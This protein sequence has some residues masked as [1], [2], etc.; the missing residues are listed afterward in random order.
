MTYVINSTAGAYYRGWDSPVKPAD[1]AYRAIHYGVVVLDISDSTIQGQF[2]CSVNCVQT[3]SD[4]MPREESVCNTPGEVIDAFSIAKSDGPTAIREITNH[5]PMEPA[6][7]NYPNPFNPSTTISYSI[8]NVA[9]VRIDVYDLPGR[10]VA[11]LVDG[12]KREGVYTC[13]WFG[14]DD[15]GN[16]LASGFYIAW[17]RSGNFVRSTKMLLVH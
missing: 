15:H 5:V 7:K 8:P 13:V 10:K 16:D 2:I 6:I 9:P 4:Y 3:G 12:V 11:T 1:C 14:K 17:L